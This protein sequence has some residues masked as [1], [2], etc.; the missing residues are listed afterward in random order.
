M[1]ERASDGVL[2]AAVVPAV[3]VTG[4]RPGPETAGATIHVGVPELSVQRA[5]CTMLGAVQVSGADM[6]AGSV[7]AAAGSRQRPGPSRRS[8]TPSPKRRPAN[9]S[10]RAA[11]VVGGADAKF[12]HVARAR[13]R[14]VGALRVPGPRYRVILLR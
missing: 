9:V 4:R 2:H 7:S 8:G 1:C 5:G 14:P 12:A 11:V 3:S 10:G 13:V 6:D